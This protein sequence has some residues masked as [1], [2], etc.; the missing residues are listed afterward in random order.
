MKADLLETKSTLSTKKIELKT[1]KSKE[2]I[3]FVEIVNLQAE[4]KALEEGIK[5]LESLEK[6]LF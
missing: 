6:E 5:A 1:A 3:N 2:D 4:I